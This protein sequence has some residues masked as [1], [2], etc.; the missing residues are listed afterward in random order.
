MSL[1][2]NVEQNQITPPWHE[3]ISSVRR[4]KTVRVGNQEFKLIYGPNNGGGKI[5]TL[6]PPVDDPSA[7]IIPWNGIS[8]PVGL[9]G[10][11]Y[12]RTPCLRTDGATSC[13]ISEIDPSRLPVLLTDKPLNEI[14]PQLFRELFH[15]DVESV[16]EI[17]VK[18]MGTG[19]ETFE[20]EVMMDGRV[21]A[22][23]FSGSRGFVK[24]LDPGQQLEGNLS[25]Y[26]PRQ[27]GGHDHIDGWA[28]AME[29]ING[30][31]IRPAVIEIGEN[32][33]ESPG[34][35]DKMVAHRQSNGRAVLTLEAGLVLKTGVSFPDLESEQ[36]FRVNLLN[37]TAPIDKY[38]PEM[39]LSE[40]Q[41]R[42]SAW[43]SVVWVFAGVVPCVII[44]MVLFKGATERPERQPVEGDGRVDVK[45]PDLGGFISG[46]IM[47]AKKFQLTNSK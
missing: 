13:E 40:I 43:E 16:S 10:G 8:F 18:K 31:S 17:T 37:H 28:G 45:L 27:S 12:L 26:V 5:V 15:R 44:G 29:V 22:F 38:S 23:V 6:H 30:E 14:N 24:S 11:A 33:Y 4:P 39:M 47:A 34:T 35:M 36:I 46:V 19:I 3:T 21:V 7:D 32:G 42:Q 25:L 2:V 41:I 1:H 20:G 9:R